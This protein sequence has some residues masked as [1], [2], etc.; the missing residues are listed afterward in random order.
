[1]AREASVVNKV[2]T[3]S[4]ITITVLPVYSRNKISNQFDLKAFANGSLTK[5]GFI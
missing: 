4:L 2:P 1:M 5:D 3:D